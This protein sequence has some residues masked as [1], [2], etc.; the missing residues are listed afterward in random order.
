MRDGGDPAL[1]ASMRLTV[2]IL[3]LNDNPPALARPLLPEGLALVEG[4][5]SQRL[6]LGAVVASDA[7]SGPNG[8]VSYA[9]HEVDCSNYGTRPSEAG[10]PRERHHFSIDRTTGQIVASGTFDRESSLH[11]CLNISAADA[12]K[13]ALSDSTIVKVLV[14]DVNDNVPRLLSNRTFHVRNTVAGSQVALLH[15]ADADAG[16]NGTLHF[17]LASSA[18]AGDLFAVDARSGSLVLV[19]EALQRD[20]GT[21]RLLLNVSDAGTPSL[22]AVE[23]LLVVVDRQSFAPLRNERLPLSSTILERLGV[24]GLVLVISVSA[25]FLAMLIM[26]IVTLAA[27]CR[28]L[29]PMTPAHERRSMSVMI[30]LLLSGSNRKHSLLIFTIISRKCVLI[31]HLYSYNFDYPSKQRAE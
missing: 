3:D 25:I 20:E 28:R 8:R 18:G 4:H 6:P 21:H 12:G 16:E 13:T 17:R 23:E 27:V 7:D 14:L 29:S 26:L 9:L 11:H 10:S 19:R 24:D 2:E 30:C 31:I 22:S 15:A 1:S 5:Y